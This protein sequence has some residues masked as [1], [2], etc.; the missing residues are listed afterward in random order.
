MIKGVLEG[1]NIA[2]ACGIGVKGRGMAG[3]IGPLCRK[4]I[5]MGYAAHDIILFKQGGTNV[6]TPTTLQYWADRQVTESKDLPVHRKKYV[7]FK[8]IE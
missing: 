3:P 2:K 5:G 8:G 4:L 1:D 6:F 7:P